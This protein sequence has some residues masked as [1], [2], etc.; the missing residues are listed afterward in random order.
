MLMLVLSTVTWRSASIYGGGLDVIV[1]AKAALA[2]LALALAWAVRI[3]TSAPRPMGTTFVWLLIAYVTVSS[4]GA[5]TADE[6]AVSGVLSVRLLLVAAGV[7]LLVKTF[8]AEQLMRDLM[9]SM[10]VVALVAAVTGV[11]SYLADGRLSGGVP[12]MHSNE[13][14][15]LCAL[16]AIGGIYLVLTNQA[17]P[18]H[19][20]ILGALLIALVGTGSRTALLTVVLAALVMLPQTRKLNPFVSIVLLACIPVTLFVMLGTGAFE[21]FFTR[22]GEGDVSTLN[23]RSIVWSAALDYPPT[24]WVRWLGN[25]L[26][27]KELPVQGQ[28]WDTQVL[29][30]SWVSA[31]VQ[32][33]WVGVLILLGWVTTAAAMTFRMA[34]GPRMLTQALLVALISRSVVESGLMDSSPAFLTFALIAFIADRGPAEPR[35]PRRAGEPAYPSRG[36]PA[37]GL[38]PAQVGRTASTRVPI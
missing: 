38:S 8:P 11:P 22:E 12:G 25:G 15:L 31:L 24:E 37:T 16:T 17:R 9:A 10:T 33:G 5:W 18:R 14:S 32:A 3:N 29:D 2:L 28:Y 30:S 34:R 27:T 35:F 21:S 6:L 23:S 7:I 19:I 20:L 13:L 26:A 1:A 36:R 4:F